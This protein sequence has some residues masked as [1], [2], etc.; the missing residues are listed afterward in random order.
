CGRVWVVNGWL[1][2]LVA[3]FRLLALPGGRLRTER[4]VER[5]D[6]FIYVLLLDDVGRQKTQDSVMSAIDQDSLLQQLP[7]DGF[8][9]VGGND[10][11]RDSVMLIG[12]IVSGAA[13]ATLDFIHQQQRARFCRQIARQLE[14]FLS[15]GINSAFALDCL[16]AD[17]AHAAIEL[18]FEVGYVVER[19]E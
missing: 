10:V 2:N 3:P 5:V 7:D 14:E 15:Y 19:D 6:D 11:R 9:G 13:E 17:S 4:T 16:H 18:A 8:G 12:E 1:L